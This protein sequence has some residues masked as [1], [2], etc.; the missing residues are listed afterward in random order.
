MEYSLIGCFITSDWSKF[1]F[2]QCLLISSA[3]DL[4]IDRTYNLTIL[5]GKRQN[6]ILFVCN[7]FTASCLINVSQSFYYVKNA[8]ITGL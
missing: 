2:F 3:A 7:E 1:T 5:R 4:W 6:L 8:K